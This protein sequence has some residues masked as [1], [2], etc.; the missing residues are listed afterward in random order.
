MTR[1]ELPPDVW[2]EEFW[3]FIKMG[4]S[5]YEVARAFGCSLDALEH[6]MRRNNVRHDW[7]KS[8]HF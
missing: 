5:R 2:V 8:P 7:S 1:R 4:M 3:G 6:R